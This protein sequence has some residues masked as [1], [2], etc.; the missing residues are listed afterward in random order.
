MTSKTCFVLALSIL[1]STVAIAQFRPGG[2]SMQKTERSLD[3][4]SNLSEQLVRLTD[5]N[6]RSTDVMLYLTC[7]MVGA[8]LVQIFLVIMQARRSRNFELLQNEI[9]KLVQ[10]IDAQNK[11]QSNRPMTENLEKSPSKIQEKIP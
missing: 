9:R 6:Q 1:F 8:T 7:V 4:L 11:L 10:V 2:P 3:S 5:A